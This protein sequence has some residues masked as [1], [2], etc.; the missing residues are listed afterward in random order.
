MLSSTTEGS[1]E[2][3]L[4]YSPAL[5]YFLEIHSLIAI[6]NQ[7]QLKKSKKILLTTS[8]FFSNFECCS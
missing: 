8:L 1:S 2:S 5:K 3:F 7:Q 4:L 6:L